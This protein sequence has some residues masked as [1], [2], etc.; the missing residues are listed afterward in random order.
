MWGGRFP[1]LFLPHPEAKSLQSRF[2]FHAGQAFQNIKEGSHLF[3][4]CPH[5]NRRTFLFI[6]VIKSCF[7]VHEFSQRRSRDNN[8]RINFK[9]P[10]NLSFLRHVSVK[11]N[12]RHCSHNMYQ[13]DDS[14]FHRNKW[15]SEWSNRPSCINRLISIPQG[16]GGLLKGKVWHRLANTSG[17]L[18]SVTINVS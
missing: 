13:S 9:L 8:T 14:K 12:H 1:K 7:K 16:E 3:L 4:H 6:S 5:R 10:Q 11:K 15:L 17:I 18:G 2:A